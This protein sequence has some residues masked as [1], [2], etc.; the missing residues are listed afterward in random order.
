MELAPIQAD[1]ASDIG[2][3]FNIGGPTVCAAGNTVTGGITILTL[4]VE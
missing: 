1:G 3:L 4:Q 2:N